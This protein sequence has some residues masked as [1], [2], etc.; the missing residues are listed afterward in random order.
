MDARC[1][2]VAV[3]ALCSLSVSGDPLV[4]RYDA[5]RAAA[6]STCQSVDADEY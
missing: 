4:N 5:L 3:L 2:V 6:I 1:L